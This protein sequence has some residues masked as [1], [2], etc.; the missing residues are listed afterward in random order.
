MFRTQAQSRLLVPKLNRAQGKTLTRRF[1]IVLA[2]LGGAGA[3]EVHGQQ[4]TDVK[5][6]QDR[7]D[8]LERQLKVSEKENEVLKREIEQ[9]KT[10]QSKSDSAEPVVKS[11]S[12]LSD[13]LADGMTLT[14]T[15]FDPNQDKGEARMIITERD[16][17]KIKGKYAATSSKTGE[18]YPGFSFEGEIV[19]NR[20]IAKSVGSA[21]K[22]TMTM[23]LKGNSFEG[24]V[25]NSFYNINV[26][27]GYILEN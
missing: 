11:K 18:V 1:V 21:N 4:T 14:G 24:T 13:R 9:L 22:R 15:Y 17:K 2:L 5:K 10:S 12:S 25:Y 19:G 7:I 23:F 3:F 20:M 6:L 8:L 27:V 26:R 16:G